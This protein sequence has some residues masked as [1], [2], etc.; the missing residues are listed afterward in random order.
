MGS[1][2]CFSPK[3]TSNKLFCLA[4]DDFLTLFINRV[5]DL[6]CVNEVITGTPGFKWLFFL[7]ILHKNII[8]NEKKAFKPVLTPVGVLFFDAI[9]SLQENSW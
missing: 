6:N 5:S 8:S 2:F 1:S 4:V 3:A 7:H 9:P